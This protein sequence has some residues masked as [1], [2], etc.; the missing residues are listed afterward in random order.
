MHRIEQADCLEWLKKQPANSIQAVCTDPPYGI[1]EFSEK[2]LAKLRIGRGG[3]WRLPPKVGGSQRDPLPRFTILTDGQKDQ[4]R[5]CFRDWANL[6]TP[7]LVARRSR[8]RGGA[9]DPPISRSERHVGW[10]AFEIRPAIVRL[11]YGFRGG[12]RP[13][14]MRETREFPEVCVSPKGAYEP[15]MLFRKPIS[16]G[17][18]ADNLRKWKTGALRR[19]STDKPLP[20]AIPSGRTP[21]ARG[22]HR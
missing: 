4:L 20:D 21:K 15:W 17:T 19:L 11:Y 8:L 13:K 3:V 7:A 1:L 18:V 6:L 10:R 14:K 5:D 12:D 2:E 9:S 16:E 22:G